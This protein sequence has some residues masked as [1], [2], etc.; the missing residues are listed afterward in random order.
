ME[1]ALINTE[2]SQPGTN[3]KLKLPNFTEDVTR[4]G[5]EDLYS[6]QESLY[7]YRH[8]YSPGLE[9]WTNF[10]KDVDSM[11]AL[12]RNVKKLNQTD[13]L[14]PLAEL[15]SGVLEEASGA[16]TPFQE[17]WPPVVTQSPVTTSPQSLTPKTL[18]KSLNDLPE[19]HPT[20]LNGLLRGASWV[21][22]LDEL[23]DDGMTFSGNGVTELE[24]RHEFLLHSSKILQDPLDFQAPGNQQEEEE[25][26]FQAQGYLPLA[27][28]PTKALEN[29]GEMTP[30]QPDT[31]Q[32]RW[33][34]SGR[35][36][37]HKPRNVQ[38]SEGSAL[39]PTFEKGLPPC[40]VKLN[41]S[42]TLTP[43]V[44]DCSPV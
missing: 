37:T 5:L 35:P 1:E 26:I 8:N 27:P 18:Q 11:F 41:N 33:N 24:T 25:D 22:Q 16:G 19:G 3:T 20:K 44:M 12:L 42:E 13:K 31:L 14:D 4:Q 21:Q 10:W 39:G 29:A 38:D 28:Q 2:H 9:D 15:G 36:L 32:E 30:S 6:V 34:E 23:D 43:Q 17:E 7:E 40:T